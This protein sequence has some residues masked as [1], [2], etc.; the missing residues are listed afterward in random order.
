MAM[1]RKKGSSLVELGAG[2]IVLVPIFLYGL[3]YASV[4]F[5]DMFNANVCREA[6]R[7][8]ASGPPT[9]FCPNM[10]SDAHRPRMRA[11][12]VVDR[13]SQTAAWIRTNPTFKQFENV[14]A[15]FPQAPYGGPV[16]GWVRIQTVATLTP[17]FMLPFVDKSV[18]L[19]H[20]EQFPYTWVMP[21]N[22]TGTAVGKR[23]AS[24]TDSD[25]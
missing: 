13:S 9:M 21:S 17:P 8:A 23:M 12:A 10:S 7:A 22:Y 11:K 15:P 16:N 1:N 18:Q 19:T 3:D 20:E 2:L 5:A 6:A 24:T 25:P 4:F 14:Q